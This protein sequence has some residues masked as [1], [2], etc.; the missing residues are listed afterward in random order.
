[1]NLTKEKFAKLFCNI[2]DRLIDKFNN[3][4]NGNRLILLAGICFLVAGLWTI[5]DDNSGGFFVSMLLTLPTFSYLFNKKK[6][7][8]IVPKVFPF[9][10]ALT[11]TLVILKIG[12]L[13]Y[14]GPAKQTVEPVS[15]DYFEQQAE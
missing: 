5:S 15:S 7:G 14:N 4:K 8:E 2:I 11:L 9:L 1:M 12:I 3:E 6:K 13:F 10:F